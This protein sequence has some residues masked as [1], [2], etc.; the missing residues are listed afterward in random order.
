M[1]SKHFKGIIMYVGWTYE[2]DA[3]AEVVYTNQD[4]S[5]WNVDH[6]W[7]YSPHPNIKKSGRG[8]GR[9]FFTDFRFQKVLELEDRD[10]SHEIDV[11]CSV[12]DMRY[13]QY[14]IRMSDEDIVKFL[15]GGVDFHPTDL[16][17]ITLR[18]VV[19][20]ESAGEFAMYYE[21]P[22]SSISGGFSVRI[23]PDEETS[24]PKSFDLIYGKQDF[25]F[26]RMAFAYEY[27]D[28]RVVVDCDF[29][30][31]QN[32]YLAT[33]NHKFFRQQ[34][35][36]THEKMGK[37]AVIC[38]DSLG[39]GLL[40]PNDRI[41]ASGSG[42]FLHTSLGSLGTDWN[43]FNH[44]NLTPAQCAGE[45][46]D[47]Y[48]LYIYIDR[49]H[50]PKLPELSRIIERVKNG[51]AG[52]IIWG[53]SANA[54]HLSERT[55]G[56]IKNTEMLYGVE[57][58]IDT[59]WG[60]VSHPVSTNVNL[61]SE[62][63][64]ARGFE[65]FDTSGGIRPV[66]NW[67]EFEPMEGITQLKEIR[68]NLYDD[69]RH[70]P[71][72]RKYWV[73]VIDSVGVNLECGR[74]RALVTV[75]DDEVQKDEDLSW[76]VGHSHTL[77]NEG[78]TESFKFS[79]NTWYRWDNSLYTDLSADK[80]KYTLGF[81]QCGSQREVNAEIRI[82][83]KSELSLSGEVFNQIFNIAPS[84]TVIFGAQDYRSEQNPSNTG[85][86]YLMFDSPHEQEWDIEFRF[87]DSEPCPGEPALPVEC[88][89]DYSINTRESSPLPFNE[90]IPDDCNHFKS[91]IVLHPCG[92]DRV[93]P[94]D[95]RITNNERHACTITVKNRYGERH[96][97]RLVGL[98]GVLNITMECPYPTAESLFP[99]PD[100]Y[101]W[102]VE[103]MADADAGETVPK[104]YATVEVHD[105]STCGMGGVGFECPE[106]TLP[107]GEVGYK[108]DLGAITDGEWYMMDNQDNICGQIYD[109]FKLIASDL[110]LPWAESNTI[111]YRVEIAFEARDHGQY[112][113][114]VLARFNGDFDSNIWTSSNNPETWRNQYYLMNSDFNVGAKDLHVERH[115]FSFRAL[116]GSARLNFIWR[117]RFN[118]EELV[119]GSW[120]SA[121]RKP[122]FQWSRKAV[123]A[124]IPYVALPETIPTNNTQFNIEENILD[125]GICVFP[126]STGL[127]EKGKITITERITY[128]GSSLAKVSVHEDV[129]GEL[130][131]KGNFLREQIPSVPDSTY[132]KQLDVTY[133]ITEEEIRIMLE[134]A[135]DGA[136]RYP[137]KISGF[138]GRQTQFL[139][140]VK[141]KCLNGNFSHVPKLHESK[142]PV[143][144]SLADFEAQYPIDTSHMAIVTEVPNSYSSTL[145]RSVKCE[146][147]YAVALRTFEGLN[148]PKATN[149]QLNVSANGKSKVGVIVYDKSDNVICHKIALTNNDTFTNAKCNLIGRI[150][151]YSLDGLSFTSGGVTP[152]MVSIELKG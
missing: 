96:V 73:E 145:R 52:L 7:S 38:D 10:S 105:N 15:I 59:D 67:Y 148:P 129:G 3:E 100:E 55:T 119:N 107:S 112:S 95:I 14:D 32:K 115:C 31:Y 132:G 142:P 81:P 99:P 147:F 83:N 60:S 35:G 46:W 135:V 5:G 16:V 125:L 61:T 89:K 123:N 120:V 47:E 64:N 118:R 84:E 90:D 30:K 26:I 19:M 106:S 117:V 139:G 33:D 151:I 87:L 93:V 88:G 127:P 103:I 39:S 29:T 141:R 37:V 128:E 113:Y 9:D 13:P 18:D 126:S 111:R 34:K 69:D 36:W 116:D 6:R 78:M 137:A 86:G 48:S 98:G 82:S 77:G 138:C 121:N 25:D 58:R 41:S 40:D 102:I 97:E 27:A 51:D 124:E 66:S 50:T 57:Q 12:R 28:A 42:E 8:G 2:I 1:G 65:G 133:V 122:Y 109:G 71:T 152:A 74:H 101:A 75:V 72:R 94:V 44:K 11:T 45:L 20:F 62:L 80:Y 146:G 150:E 68:L 134:G 110:S 49:L 53:E 92:S 140:M 63:V 43:L 149:L 91:Q 4:P 21:V 70:Q 131:G 17:C 143:I 56:V 144:N 54:A 22:D 104:I 108:W 85:F 76:T 24:T 114:D 23:Y 136:Y 130:V 79:S